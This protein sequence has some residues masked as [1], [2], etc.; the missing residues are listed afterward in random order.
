MCWPGCYRLPPTPP[1]LL[2]PLEEP[3]PELEPESLPLEPE[4]LES[5]ELEPLIGPSNGNVQMLRLG[6]HVDPSGHVSPPLQSRTHVLAPSKIMSLHAGTAVAPE[7]PGQQL[8]ASMQPR[9]QTSKVSSM[10]LRHWPPPAQNWVSPM[11]SEYVPSIG[12]SGQSPVS[13]VTVVPDVLIVVADV[14]IVA[15]AVMFI[16]VAVPDDDVVLVVPVPVE[17]PSAPPPLSP[18]ADRLRQRA[19]VK[20]LKPRIP[21]R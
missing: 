13:V 6:S 4:P 1:E 14:L 8:Q 12:G 5:D 16:V 18:Q 3:D 20:T 2:E 19:N 17:P 15:L 11:H 9:V 10:S 21:P 7:T